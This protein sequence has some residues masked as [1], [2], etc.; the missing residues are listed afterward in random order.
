MWLRWEGGFCHLLSVIA[1]LPLGVRD[2]RAVVVSDVV[3]P[4]CQ[5]SFT[6]ENK[7]ECMY[8]TCTTALEKE[9]ERKKE[10]EE[11]SGVCVWGGGG[12]G[13]GEKRAGWGTGGWSSLAREK[14]T[15]NI[16]TRR[17]HHYEV[18]AFKVNKK[19]SKDIK[20]YIHFLLLLSQP[21]Y[22]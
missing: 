4:I 2:V 17:K 14:R 6:A 1:S 18:Y 20:T 21:L 19:E 16:N 5:L 12:W 22:M 3:C 10:E 13:G 9:K 7:L 15:P 11:R 8:F